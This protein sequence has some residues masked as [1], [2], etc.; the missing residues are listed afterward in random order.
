MV[1][2]I[3]DI[4]QTKQVLIFKV[5]DPSFIN[6]D[7]SHSHRVPLLGYTLFPNCF[8]KYL[9]MKLFFLLQLIASQE[10]KSILTIQTDRVRSLVSHGTSLFVG[11]ETEPTFAITQ[12]DQETGTR[13]KVLRGHRGNV[14]TLIMVNNTL[15]SG[16]SDTSIIQWDIE[17][18]TIIKTFQN[19][20][21]SDVLAFAVRGTQLYS[22]GSDNTIRQWDIPTGT[23]VKTIPGHQDKITGLVFKNNLL[24]SS[25]F[26]L[27]VKEWNIDDWTVQR[28]FTGHTEGIWDLDIQGD[29]L[30]TAS[31]DTTV[32]RYD[33]ITGQMIRTFRGHLT[34]IF[35]LKVHGNDLFTGA[36]DYTV[37]KWNIDQGTLTTTFSEHASYALCIEIS[38]GYL[39]TGSTDGTIKK[40]KVDLSPLN[41]TTVIQNPGTTTTTKPNNQNDGYPI[42]SNTLFSIVLSGLVLLL[43]SL[44]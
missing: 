1:A 29:Y 22:G 33:L 32:K 43:T 3:Q 7:V 34:H 11:S 9:K 25:G 15:I 19:G 17:T 23:L 36:F 28:N 31:D 12:Y 41:S 8:P 21:T 10:N 4:V 35:S 20:H 30:Y 38:N 42:V 24:Y 44:L 27:M 40:W 6:A 2:Y 14:N 5:S 26:D 37:R 13:Q 16:S 18:G 39:Y